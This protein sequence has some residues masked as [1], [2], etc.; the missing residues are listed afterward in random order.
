MIRW[1]ANNEQKPKEASTVT[2]EMKRIYDESVLPL[3]KECRFSEF[4]LEEMKAADFE[5]KP[6]VLLLGQYSV[7]KTTFIKTLLDRETPGMRIGPE[8]TT[9]QFN[10]I[11]HG[12]KEQIL[13]GHTAVND[14]S[15]PFD[16]LGKFGQNFL[17]RL[18]VSKVPSQV[19]ESVTLIDTPGVLAGTKQSTARGYDFEQIVKWFAD[20]VDMII[21]LFD[22][23]K[24]DI[25]DEFRG[26]IESL[27]GNEKKVKVVLNKADSLQSQSMLRVYGALMWN[28]GKILNTPE[29]C[30]VYIGSWWDGVI[31]NQEQRHVFEKEHQDL[32]KELGLLPQNCALRKMDDLIKRMNLLRAFAY[33]LHELK[34][35]MPS[36]VG[37]SSYWER[38]VED[39]ESVYKKVMANHRIARG[40]FP[41]LSWMQA[42]L[43]TKDKTYAVRIR[44]V[45][46]DKLEAVLNTEVSKLIRRLQT[47][48]DT[49]KDTAFTQ[50]MMSASPFK[51]A[52]SFDGIE[53]EFDPTKYKPQFL[54]AGPVDGI[55]TGARAKEVLVKTNLPAQV[56]HRIWILAD[57]KQKGELDFYSFALAM[58]FVDKKLRGDSLPDKLPDKLKPEEHWYNA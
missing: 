17:S 26:T 25:S 18:Q 3:E 21:L 35:G 40:D 54:A 10:I 6:Q 47:D 48:S 39:L 23:H 37:K 8:P 49:T 1:L 32:Y 22:A 31:K 42:N 56:L 53:A 55:L 51:E 20:R 33:V 43:R 57:V 41:K 44:P 5:T 9:D 2:K 38:S 46:M 29:V 12:H 27:K 16:G 45:L 13:N 11:V 58:Y 15:M 14:S 30:R 7:G 24:L 50:Q 19:L 52:G 4:F 34:M 36:V 28:L